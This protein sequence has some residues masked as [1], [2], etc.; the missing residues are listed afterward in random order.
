MINYLRA[1]AARFRGLL[2]NRG[3]DRELDDE[4][5]EHL[6]LL[7]ERHIRQGMS[8]DEAASVARVNSEMSDCSRR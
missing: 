4:I 5:K 7:T 1:L 2:R 8:E 6:H 3:A